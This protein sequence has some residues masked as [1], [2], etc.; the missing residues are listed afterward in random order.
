MTDLKLLDVPESP[1]TRPQRP[2][3]E[4][5]LALSMGWERSQALVM[6]HLYDTLSGELPVTGEDMNCWVEHGVGFVVPER[7]PVSHNSQQIEEY[8]YIKEQLKLAIQDSKLPCD[9]VLDSLPDGCPIFVNL[10]F[11]ERGVNR[12]L[13]ALHEYRA[14][15]QTIGSS[16]ITAR[17]ESKS[18]SDLVPAIDVSWNHYR[19]EEYW[20]AM[21]YTVD[22][23][24]EKM[25][26]SE[27]A[28]GDS[29]RAAGA[30]K[31][32][33]ATHSMVA[34]NDTGV[35]SPEIPSTPAPADW[36]KSAR[37]IAQEFF[38]K[39]TANGLRD[40]LIRQD[41]KGG[42]AVRVMDEMRKRKIHGPRGPID[43]PATI[44]REALQGPKWWGRM[45]K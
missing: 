7:E 28:R 11:D 44:A 36:M 22:D 15:V 4:E 14:L 24:V 23:Y 29:A 30:S 35:R 19:S 43:N 31:D 18:L 39:D 40:S 20:D 1:P 9:P 21:P 16:I 3:Y 45:P 42:Y 38:D 8:V 33:D 34:R 6:V 2:N 17:G 25:G 27:R 12:W 13:I 10:S 37:A 41:G 26:F 32:S 5:V